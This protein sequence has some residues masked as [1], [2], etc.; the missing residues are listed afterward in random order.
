MQVI[1]QHAPE[2]VSI[3]LVGTKCDLAQGREVDFAEGNLFWK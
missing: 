3:V 2:S 1:N